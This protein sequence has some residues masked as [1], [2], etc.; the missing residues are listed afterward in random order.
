MVGEAPFTEK[1]TT[2]RG[3]FDL[4]SAAADPAASAAATIATAPI[5]TNLC[6]AD[7]LRPSL[8][9]PLHPWS[10]DRR[11]APKVLPRRGMLFWTSFRSHQRVSSSRRLSGA[12]TNFIFREG[13]WRAR[14]GQPF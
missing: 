13:S 8:L 2:F 5:E 10:G 4:S 11:L 12:A 6:L 7:I 3:P 14:L 1:T 9:G